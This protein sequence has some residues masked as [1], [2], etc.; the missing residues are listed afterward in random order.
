LS[1]AFRIHRSDNV[2]TLL[3][4]ASSGPLTV[5]GGGEEE[6][7]VARE[8]IKIGHKVALRDIGPGEAIT[9]FGVPI[10]RASQPIPQGAWVHLHNCCSSFDARSQTFDVQTGATTDVVYE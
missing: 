5:T 9:K 8:P 4:D 3:E 6:Q 10:G 7:V 1:R 2:A